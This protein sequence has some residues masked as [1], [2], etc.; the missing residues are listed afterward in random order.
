MEVAKPVCQVSAAPCQKEAE[1]R[2]PGAGKTWK[3]ASFRDVTMASLH[4][5]AFRNQ[6]STQVATFISYLGVF[7]IA[8]SNRCGFVQVCD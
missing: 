6:V 1:V 2:S 3:E 8:D 5:M 4:Q 7:C